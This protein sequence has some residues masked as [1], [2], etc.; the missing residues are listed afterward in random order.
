MFKIVA[1][2]LLTIILTAAKAQII[3]KIDPVKATEIAR[4]IWKNMGHSDANTIE[5]RFDAEEKI[6]SF[7]SRSGRITIAPYIVA[8]IEKKFGNDAEDVLAIIIAHELRHREQGKGG[9]GFAAETNPN[10][11]EI[12]QDADFQGLLAAH[13]AGYDVVKYYDSLLITK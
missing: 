2:S 1:L 12:E 8:L 7:D 4:K 6:A 5:V 13:L 9:L 3:S 11:T 10:E